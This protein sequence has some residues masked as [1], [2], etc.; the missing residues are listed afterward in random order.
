MSESYMLQGWRDRGPIGEES[1]QVERG[2][3][4][5][6]LASSCRLT[7]SP[8][9]YSQGREENFTPLSCGI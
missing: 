9:E 1:R 4:R 6:N 3:V 8:Q 5:E 2:I 7:C